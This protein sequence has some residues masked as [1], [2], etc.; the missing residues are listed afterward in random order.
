MQE[1]VK[2]IGSSHR[3]SVE[4]NLTSIH[5]DACSVPGL[6]RG[7]RIAVSYGVGRRRG[8]DPVLLWLWCR[9]AV[10]APIGPLAWEPPYAMSVALKR[11]KKKMQ[12]GHVPVN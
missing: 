10:V 2:Y 5:K 1:R 11:K 9:P 7:L 6:V 4:M 8:L 12:I 3:G